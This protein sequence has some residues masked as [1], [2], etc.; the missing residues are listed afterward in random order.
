MAVS[1]ELSIINCTPDV[2]VDN[3]SLTGESEL[4]KRDWKP[5]DETPTGSANLCFFDTLV[6]NGKG[7]GAQLAISIATGDEIFMG[8]PAQLAISTATGDEIFM[9][10]PTQLA[11]STAK[12]IKDFV[13]KVSLFAFVLGIIFFIIGMVENGN[14]VANV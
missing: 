10:R 8:R 2:E 4:Q 5:I 3:S 13:F 14:L 11:I 7:R 6:V 12:E 9:G 1:A